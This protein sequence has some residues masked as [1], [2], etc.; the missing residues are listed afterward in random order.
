MK[1]FYRVYVCDGNWLP[2]VTGHDIND[3]SNG[4]EIDVLKVYYYSPA[5]CTRFAAFITR[6]VLNL[7]S[8]YPE[9]ID[10]NIDGGM[11]GHAG[12]VARRTCC[13]DA[14]ASHL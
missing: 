10:D 7:Q 11:D 12:I 13:T 2:G 8:Y 6:S 1:I 3:D 4:Q 9:Q 5:N 14:G